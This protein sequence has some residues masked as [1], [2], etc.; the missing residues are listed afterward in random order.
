MM[1]GSRPGWPFAGA[2]LLLGGWL[3][4]A[5]ALTAPVSTS[6]RER[7]SSGGSPFSRARRGARDGCQPP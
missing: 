1:K 7:N 6:T 5:C 3:I 4:A 2:S